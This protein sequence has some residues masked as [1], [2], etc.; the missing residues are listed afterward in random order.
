MHCSVPTT[1]NYYKLKAKKCNIFNSICAFQG[2]KGRKKGMLV[3]YESDKGT[4]QG[5]LISPVLA[6]VYLH[7]V[8]DLWFEKW[9][10]PRVK[11]EVYLIRYADDCAPRRQDSYAI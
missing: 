6:N 11:G 7:Y 9:V 2:L 8:L 3:N 5:G 4:P 10:K 1:D